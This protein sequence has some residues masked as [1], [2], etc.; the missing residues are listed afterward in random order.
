MQMYT[1]CQPGLINKHTPLKCYVALTFVCL[2]HHYSEPKLGSKSIKK[3]GKG[4]NIITCKNQHQSCRNFEQRL[5]IK[6]IGMHDHGSMGCPLITIRTTISGHCPQR[7]KSLT[8]QVLQDRENLTT[9]KIR[10]TLTILKICN[11]NFFFCFPLCPFPISIYSWWI[12]F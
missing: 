11:G 9:P 7:G 1:R 2:F 3:I 12:L 8:P 10:K 5:V 6:T 4:Q